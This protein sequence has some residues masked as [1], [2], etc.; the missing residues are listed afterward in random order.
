MKQ[1]ACNILSGMNLAGFGSLCLL[2]A[3][4][5]PRIC[6]YDDTALDERCTGL[7]R[8]EAPVQEASEVTR[9]AYTH[10]EQELL[11]LQ[12][13]RLRQKLA[14]QQ[15]FQV[16]SKLEVNCVEPSLATHRLS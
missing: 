9:A 13:L 6:V 16:R 10:S 4:D 2:H 7:N 8:M 11:E 14:L 3:C 1:L 5:D 12:I 15:L